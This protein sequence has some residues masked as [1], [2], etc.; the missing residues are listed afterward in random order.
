MV[1]WHFQI[2][3]CF[4]HLG[5]YEDDGGEQTV[6]TVRRSSHIARGTL[7]KNER[8][9]Y[10]DAVVCLQKKAAK[11][12]ASFAAGAKTRFDVS[13]HTSAAS[14]HVLT[15]TFSQDWVATHISQSL[16][17]HYTG[18]FLAWHRWFTWLYEQAL[19]D[20]CGYTGTQPYWDWALTAR[21]GLEASSIFDGSDY[22]M[23]GNGERI[24]QTGEIV[25]GGGALPFLFL[26]TGTGGGCVTTGPF[27]NM[28]VNL[29]PAT[30]AIPGN[31]T[32]AQPNPLDYN[33]RC[34]KRDISDWINRRFS[35]ATSIINTLKQKTIM[36][37]QMVMQGVPGS[38]DLGI[39]GGGHY[40][41]GK[42]S[43][44]PQSR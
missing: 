41:F 28:T 20:E 17:I 36:D 26:P 30:L 2:I 8:K 7:S 3:T 35:N 10:T 40:S 44:P 5:Q 33:P 12:P 37:F 27:K 6:V 38:G 29:G 34:L 9:A 31:I 43:K 14:G 42:T 22:S 21:T 11:A 19:R 1:S 32:L 4:A 23:G 18:T 39:H 15:S 13:L 25:L 24:A 16:T